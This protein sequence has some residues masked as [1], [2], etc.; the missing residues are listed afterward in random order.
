MFFC[1]VRPAVTIGIYGVVFATYKA[2]IY[3]SV[4]HPGEQFV[5][6]GGVTLI[7]PRLMGRTTV[8]G[9]PCRGNY[10]VLRVLVL[11]LRLPSSGWLLVVVNVASINMWRGLCTSG[12]FTVPETDGTTSHRRFRA[13]RWIFVGFGLP[14]VCQVT[15]RPDIA[16]LLRVAGPCLGR[17]Y[18]RRS[19]F[20]AVR[21]GQPGVGHE[22]RDF[23]LPSGFGLGI[24]IG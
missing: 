19:H 21:G 1:L 22:L 23:D 18:V 7:D 17:A 9:V 11:G 3:C 15:R 2:T 6:L 24:G 20:E 5:T 13:T 16:A 12:R 14:F 8:H 10:L 4:A